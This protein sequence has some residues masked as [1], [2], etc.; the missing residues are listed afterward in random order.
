LLRAPSSDAVVE[1]ASLEG[2][3]V[4]ALKQAVRGDP[5]LLEDVSRRVRHI[6]RRAA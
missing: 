6:E 4:R 3:L 5:E 2:A 1:N